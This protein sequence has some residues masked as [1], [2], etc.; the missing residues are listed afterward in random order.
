MHDL[1][2]ARPELFTQ[3][4]RPRRGLASSSL[5]ISSLS[6]ARAYSAATPRAFLMARS[7]E[8]PW[9]MMQMPSMP[10]SGAPPYAL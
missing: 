8:L 5:T 9:Q 10:S 1:P 2:V 6:L 7:P 3:A 4:D